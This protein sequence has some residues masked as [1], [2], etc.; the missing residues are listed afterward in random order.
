MVGKLGRG[1]VVV[2]DH[3]GKVDGGRRHRLVL[4]ELAIGAVQ[5]AQVKSLQDLGISG[6][7][8]RVVHGGRDQFVEVQVLDI[9]RA[10]HMGAAV[11]QDLRHLGLVGEG[12]ELRLHRVRP[13]RHLAERQR[14]GEKLDQDRVH[15]P[16]R[17]PDLKGGTLI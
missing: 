4:A 11:A 7:R 16:G 5:V 17:A 14:G 3:L 8:L 1:L 12:I 15:R 6:D 13:G 2:G 9:E 10:A